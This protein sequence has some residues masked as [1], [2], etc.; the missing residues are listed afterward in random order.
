L[1]NARR[2]YSMGV[3]L[4]LDNASTYRDKYVEEL[5]RPGG[6]IV[7][8]MPRGMPNLLLGREGTRCMSFV[9][10]DAQNW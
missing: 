9:V 7:E 10:N 5:N 8:G 1:S 2:D 4:M 3:E 6:V